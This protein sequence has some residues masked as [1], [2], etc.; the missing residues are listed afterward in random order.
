[1]LVVWMLMRL[2][3]IVGWELERP[4]RVAV[5]FLLWEGEA[6]SLERCPFAQGA[7]GGN[8][9][10]GTRKEYRALPFADEGS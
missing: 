5:E 7:S 3:P 10:Y 4:A 2:S 9:M 1:M 6:I 8:E